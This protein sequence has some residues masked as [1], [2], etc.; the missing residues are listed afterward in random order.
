MSKISKGS[1]AVLAACTL[2]HFIHHIH[3]GALSPFLPVIKNELSLTLTEAGLIASVSVFTMTLTHFIVGY[4]GDKGVREVFIQ[5]TIIFS[6]IIILIS[7]LATTFLYLTFCMIL[8]GIAASGYHPNAV[9]KLAEW[10]PKEKRAHATGIQS[11]GGVFGAAIIPLVGVILLE[12]LGGWRE[13][14]VFLGIIGIITFIPVV[15]LMRYS[16]NAIF[17][18][19]EVSLVSSG[20]EKWTRNFLISLCIKGIRG[21]TFQCISLLMPLYLVESYGFEPLWAGSLTTIMLTSGLFG[22][23]ASM[24]LSDRMNRRV[25]FMIAS[26]GIVTPLL[27]LLNFSLTGFYLILILI[28]IG[29]F[30]F[31]GVPAF[32]AWLSEVSPKQSQGFAFG[33]YFSIGA[34][35]GALSPFI[36]G[37]I[38][39]IYGLEMS[40][41]FLVITT[42]SSTVLALF[43]KESKKEILKDIPA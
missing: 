4:L 3:T 31:F 8:L 5:L 16:E 10:I 9:P 23:F 14:Y 24:K 17:P 33:L 40:I 30:Y 35:P 12:L 7:S 20:E 13:S 34:L 28:L 19:E 6:S 2:T 43:L 15:I 18:S 36:F 41:L 25:P 27:L 32:M 26:T 29:F 21:M 22:E 39:D 1:Y 11:M 42:I 37:A 38:G